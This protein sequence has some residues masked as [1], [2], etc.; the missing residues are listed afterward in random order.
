MGLSAKVEREQQQLKAFIELVAEFKKLQEK[1]E[2][3][4]NK[5]DALNTI[6]TKEKR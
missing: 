1:I 2:E 4:N 6:K 5:L 3:I